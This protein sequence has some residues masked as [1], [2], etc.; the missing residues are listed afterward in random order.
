M[1]KLLPL[2]C[3]VAGVV[4]EQKVDEESKVIRISQGQVR[5]Y[6]DPQE[7]I[8]V[9]YGI[10]YARAPTGSDRYKAPLPAPI[11]LE[12]L[13]AVDKGVVCPQ[14]QFGQFTHEID[15]RE[16]CLIAN[17]YLPNTSEKNIP[18]VVYVHGGAFHIGYGDL[19]TP[20]KLVAS[21]N[22]IVVTFNYR[23]GVHGFLCL[24]S[25]YAPGNAGMKDQV[26][27]LRWVKKNIGSFGG[28]PNDV[29]IAGY[30]AGSASV[31]MLLLS[32]L[33]KGLF[34]RAIPESGS[35]TAVWA[36][37]RNPLK[38]AKD[39]AK[40]LNFTNVDDFY[41]LEEFYKTASYDT[42]T[43]KLFLDIPDSTFGF[44][45]CVER[46]TG[47]D[48]FLDDTP[49]NI[50]K[51]GKYN[52][53]PLLYGFA[54]MEGLFRLP[55]FELWRDRM[56]EKF[57]EFLPADLQFESEEQKE[58]IAEQI[59]KFYF[60]DNPISPDTVSNYVDYYTDVLFAYPALRSVRL[61]VE[62]GNDKIYLY[63]YSFVEDATDPEHYPNLRGANHCAQSTA[64][65]DGK[66]VIDRNEKEI[67]NEF[68][69][70]KSMV[71]DIW[72]NFIKTGN[73]VPE[74]SSYPAWPP[75]NADGFPFMDIGS[76]LQLKG[77][78]L[79]ERMRFWD[80][81]YEQY[82]RA[83]SPPPAPPAN[84]TYTAVCDAMWVYTLVFMYA[85][86]IFPTVFAINDVN[87]KVV[88]TR[89]G[90]VRGYKDPNIGIFTF[91]GIPYATAP[92]GINR[93][94]APLPPPIWLETFEAVDKGIICMQANDFGNKIRQED[95]LI[96]NV[97]VPD[98]N[99]KNLPVIIYVHGGAFQLAYGT[100]LTPKNLVKNKNVIAVT[101]NYRVGVHGFLC[102][103]TE[104]IPGNAGMKDQVALLRWVKENIVAFG[105][106]P[107]EVTIAGYSTGSVSVDLLTL[108]PSTRGLFK[109]VIPESGS[110][111]ALFAVQSD[112]LEIAKKYAKLFNFTDVNNF[113][114]LENFYLNTSLETLSE[115]LF[116]FMTKTDSTLGFTPCV[117]RD[118]GEETFLVDSPM[119]I[120]QKGEFE[121]VPMLYG[122][123]DMEG[124]SRIEMFELW[125]D[126]MNENF[127]DFLPADLYFE[128]KEQKE[129]VAKIIKEFYFKNQT[130]GDDTVLAYINYFSDI[131]YTY[132]MLKSAKLQ[133]DAGNDRVYFYVYSFV[134]DD[135][136]PV[137][138]FPN[139]NGADHCAQTA[140][141]LDGNGFINSD[142]D[143]SNLSEAFTTIKATMR[144]LW[145]NFV[146]TGKPV[147]D[148][149][150][151]LL[152]P[153]VD[154]EYYSYMS[155]DRKL[156]LKGQLLKPQYHFWD[157]I[158]ERHYRYPKPP[159][160]PPPKKV[161]L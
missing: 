125:K 115:S 18:V 108:S 103:G 152:W 69:K 19:V 143:E 10:P 9:F 109:R 128:N 27:L 47:E 33:A 90:L 2:V 160:I 141:I 153:P 67:S 5:G 87:S 51:K 63:E 57:S 149:S 36:V 68:Q 21:Q 156:Q 12:T 132:S 106:N 77:T 53:V 127:S 58:L 111:I 49:V 38:N 54:N 144:E 40:T 66:F 104:N 86:A 75:A 105:G 59:K 6:K 130:V 157:E 8:F 145:H 121:K 23:L 154:A 118:I 137:P 76:E 64:V 81:I 129:E 82:Y 4:C 7:D 42:L 79:E 117:E 28:N 93:Y 146:T 84:Q 126:K 14:P 34:N 95:C 147:L 48:K 55:L 16:D 142:D 120:L 135:D 151:P 80:T 140:A 131:L 133:M 94:K 22:V 96:A 161:E 37:Q 65:L 72:S 1:W 20:K 99:E 110:N 17:V 25:E 122:M 112:P 92:T 35:N 91:Y 29:T 89:Q 15:S 150:F 136:I 78:L 46:D 52:K 148:M 101:F 41:A 11:W 98:T 107:D 102:M 73:P 159:P 71:R 30:S 44:S 60:K 70:V 56:N 74:G 100:F 116:T 61:Q 114:A 85:A 124:L 134:D 138:N 32:P 83:P 39:Y 119:N 26:A 31:D 155:L 88:K 123:A 43:S 24:G 113:Y 13:E 50:L 158:Y 45:L 97:Y 139:I 3:L 62:S